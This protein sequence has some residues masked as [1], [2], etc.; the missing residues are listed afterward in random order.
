MAQGKR[1]TAQHLPPGQGPRLI[2]TY[3][4][5]RKFHKFSFVVGGLFI[6]QLQCYRYKILIFRIC[7][8]GGTLIAVLV[9]L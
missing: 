5:G 8:S 7:S 3:F 9:E 2:A 6:Y 1:S 4:S